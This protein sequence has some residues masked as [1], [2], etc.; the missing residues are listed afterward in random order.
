DEHRRFLELCPVFE[1][2]YITAEGIVLAKFWLEVSKKEQE[3]RFRARIDDPVR[4]WKLSSMDLPS[5]S[6]W[7]DYSRARDMMLDATDTKRA[8]WYILRSEDKKRAR[9]NCIAHILEL[10]PYK[11]VPREKISLPKRSMKG[12]YDD[13]R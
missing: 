3:R 5:R 13:V 12:A 10:I 8:P 4:Q 1:K 9:L 7:Y 6:R 2:S 11:K